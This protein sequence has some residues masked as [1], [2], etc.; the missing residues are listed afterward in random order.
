MRCNDPGSAPRSADRLAYPPRVPRHATTVR[1]TAIAILSIVVIGGASPAIAARPGWARDID[2]VIG[3]RDVSVAVA[4]H[5]DWL[6]RHAA[7]RLR[8][9]ASNQKLL[10]SMALLQRTSLTA[11]IRT[12]VFAKGATT[13]GV[14]HGNL[15][16]VGHGDPE[17]NKATMGSL[18][19]AIEASGIE[20]VRGRVL[21]ATTGFL[22][23]WWAPGWRDYFPRDYIALPTALTF[24]RNED[25]RGVHIRDPERRAARS[26]SRKLRARGVPVTMEAGAGVPPDGLRL[27]VTQRSTTFQALLRHMLTRSRNFHAEVLGKWLGR[28][29][30]GSP[31]SI[32]KGAR[33]L[34]SFAEAHGVDVAAY[35]ASGLSYRNR[36]RPQ[37]L[38]TL[39]RF[40]A[41]RS[42]GTAF[43]ASL[44][45][46]DQGT[47]E[48]RL[49]GVKVR[50]K[51]GTLIDISTLSGW[52]WL[53]QEGGWAEFSIMSRGM[54]KDTAA[55]IEDRIVR[56][57]SNRA[58][59]RV[60]RPLGAGRAGSLLVAP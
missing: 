31:G 23:D 56:I 50:A 14:L 20:K 45:T 15:W 17:V 42:W 4:F 8:T 32:A 3:D 24:E 58:R 43:R 25:S 6:Y 30:R 9:P 46:G 7:W 22:H 2:D 11:R 40:E 18:A 60:A 36:V 13:N 16:I 53:E 51:T 59:Q 34:E 29:V 12:E 10:L 55:A 57:L 19:R 54:S 47:L 35:D 33:V 44:P 28:L 5:G 38:V 49:I 26:L 48:D 37:D 39:L 21:G 52:V 1:T 41:T 27:L